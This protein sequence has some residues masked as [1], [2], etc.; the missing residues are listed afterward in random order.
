MHP[1]LLKKSQ[2]LDELKNLRIRRFQSDETAS[3]GEIFSENVLSNF[4]KRSYQKSVP[5]KMSTFES[6]I[7]VENLI[8]PKLLVFSEKLINSKKC[9][10]V[11]I[12]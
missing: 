6:F 7:S 5:P 10:K 11:A 3:E 8:T 9:N 12:L 1:L 2:F 4:F